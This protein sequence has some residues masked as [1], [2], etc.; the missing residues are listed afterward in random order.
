MTDDPTAATAATYDEIAPAYAERTKSQPQALRGWLDRFAGAMPAGGTVA[1]LGCGPA[2]D[3]ARL[4]ARGL[5]AVGVDRSAGMLAVA[6]VDGLPGRVVQGD[7]RRLPLRTGSVDGLWSSAALLH[8]PRHDVPGALAELHRVLRPGGVL[9]LVTALGSGERFE[10][11]DYAAG[12]HRWFV[13]H[14]AGSL[15]RLTGQ[16]GFTLLA[17]SERR[18]NRHW[19]QLLARAQ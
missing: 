8:V 14:D 5:L 4:A 16:A 2:R 6:A 7:L 13:Y 19:L 3:G 12:R 9:G 11:V 17:E 18:M 1:D 10:E 15:R